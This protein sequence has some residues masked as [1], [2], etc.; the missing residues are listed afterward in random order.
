MYRKILLPIDITEPAMT[1][2]AIAVAQQLAKAFD[3][4]MR[5]VNVQSLLPIAFLDYVPENFDLQVRNGL[6]KEIAAVAAKIDYAPERVS[7]IVLFGPVYQ[8]VLAEAE[9]WGADLIV[10]CSH[11]PGM[12]RFLIGSEA[13]AIVNHARCSV[14]V[15]RGAAA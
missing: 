11:R 12:D 2:R 3:S 4:E 14:L 6:E 9:A 1:D 15:V 13:T 5:L 7:T 10:L 8:K